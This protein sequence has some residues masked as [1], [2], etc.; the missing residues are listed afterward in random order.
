MAVFV[1]GPAIARFALRCQWNNSFM[2][3]IKTHLNPP[4]YRIRIFHHDPGSIAD[5][6]EPGDTSLSHTLCTRLCCTALLYVHVINL[7][8]LMFR[9]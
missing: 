6:G 2:A 7:Y 3:G 9:A 5:I 4:H 8:G 1:H